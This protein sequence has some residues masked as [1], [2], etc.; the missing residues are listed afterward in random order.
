M[1]I[2]RSIHKGELEKEW[3]IIDAKDKV[4]GRLCS[5]VAKILL[6]K[7]KPTYTPNADV[8]DFVVVI[9]A[10]KVKVTGK[11]FTDKMYEKYSGYPGGRT[12]RTYKEVLREKPTRIIEEAVRGMIPHSKL[13]NVMYKKLKVYTGSEHPHCSQNPKQI[14]VTKE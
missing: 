6:G 12:L 4:L 11:K 5:N 1:N 7:H 9:N 14:T 3:Y 2:T 8:G 10:E 13:G